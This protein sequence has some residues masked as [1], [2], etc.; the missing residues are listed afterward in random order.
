MPPSPIG[1]P[2][3]SP[4]ERA[5]LPVAALLSGVSGLLYQEMW[6]RALRLGFGG[7]VRATGVVLAAFVGGIGLGSVW[8]GRRLERWGSP[9]RAYGWM[10][11][12]IAVY[13]L[14]SLPILHAVDRAHAALVD[15]LADGALG[16]VLRL[17]LSLLALALPTLLMGGTL[18]ALSAALAAGDDPGRSSVGRAYGAN[19]L[20]AMLGALLGAFWLLGLLGMRGSVLAAAAGNAIAAGLALTVARRP[21]ARAPA[22]APEPAAL[23]FPGLAAAAAFASGVSTITL[24]VVWTRV[25]TGPLG[26]AHRVFGTMLAVVLCGIGAGALAAARWARSHTASRGDYALVVALQGLTALALLPLAGPIADLLYLA[27]PLPI[28]GAGLA[29]LGVLVLAAVALPTAFFAG[30]GYPMLAAVAR[31]GRQGLSADVG[32]LGLGSALG[33]VTGA[34]GTSFL[35]LPALGAHASVR[36]AASVAAIVA[37]AMAPR[38]KSAAVAIA[39][40]ALV[41]AALPGHL[42]ARLVESSVTTFGRSRSQ[43]TAKSLAEFQLRSRRTREFFEEGTDATAIV[44]RTDTQ[45]TMYVNGKPDASSWLDMGTQTLVG[46]L[47]VLV[48]PEARR[49]LVIGLGSGTSV[50]WLAASKNMRHVDVAEIEPAMARAARL[51][52][53]L[54]PPALGSRKV[55]LAFVDG[56]TVV[57]AGGGG[58]R[59]DVIA[60]E[61]SNPW[62]GGAASLYTEELYAAARARLGPRGVFAQWLQAYRIDAPT[63]ALVIRTFT[64]AFRHTAMVYSGSQDVVLIGSAAPL[65]LAPETLGARLEALGAFPL[66]A[67]RLGLAAPGDLAGCV[68]ATGEGLAAL[69][70]A[71]EGRV[72]TDDNALLEVTAGGEATAATADHIGS[73]VTGTDRGA[74]LLRALRVPPDGAADFFLSQ[75]RCLAEDAPDAARFVRG[76]GVQLGGDPSRA[77]APTRPALSSLREAA[78]ALASLR[79]AHGIDPDEASR[80]ARALGQLALAGGADAEAAMGLL[81]TGFPAGVLYLTRAQLLLELSLGRGDGSRCARAAATLVR[82]HVLDLPVLEQ[83]GRCVDQGEAPELRAP[84]ARLLAVAQ[85]VTPRGI[86]SE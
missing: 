80:I 29:V 15:P 68:L 13:G 48:R 11:V 22:S 67:A 10:E 45:R 44:L 46:A 16:S 61:P 58:R 23:P 78:R 3:R 7:S 41:L 55:R 21:A 53:H 49:A 42:P 31:P 56:R 19:T 9:A 4:F 36:L 64:R 20:G 8:I 66:L 71:A 52:E 47:P 50:G 37:L 5:A 63:L 40:V 70:E 62:L 35:V 74:S 32:A 85:Q 59:W 14:L 24:E 17:S 34:L 39:A 28:G 73:I 86:A 83:A 84:L 77:P 25:L 1:S 72:H 81:E 51:F 82:A 76:V 6:A 27:V 12:G 60:S 65:D 79:A 2:S 54:H 69:G 26:G 38:V 18:P 57:M 75:A 43:P 33:S 30:V